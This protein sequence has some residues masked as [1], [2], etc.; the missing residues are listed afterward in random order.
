MASTLT[1][2]DDLNVDSGAFFVDASANSVG[3]NTASPQVALHVSSTG[4]EAV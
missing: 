2:A 4:K 3:I 1:V